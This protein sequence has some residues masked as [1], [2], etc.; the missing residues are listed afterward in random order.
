M[1]HCR[2]RGC[3]ARYVPAGGLPLHV[4]FYCRDK[5]CPEIVD[6]AGK[7]CAHIH[8]IDGV[9]VGLF[10]EIGEV[11]IKALD[12][13]VFNKNGVS[14]QSIEILARFPDKAEIDFAKDF[15]LSY[16]R[17]FKLSFFYPWTS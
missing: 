13:P 12:L 9:I 1:F 14:V 16:N 3:F 2:I 7:I 4:K 8:G 17:P 6:S 10:L 15:L 5:G 11:Y